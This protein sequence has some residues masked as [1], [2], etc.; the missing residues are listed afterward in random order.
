[1]HTPSLC[2][3]TALTLCAGLAPLAGAGTSDPWADFVVDFNQGS[4]A[5]PSFADPTTAL[6]SPERFTGEG[7]F[8]GAVTPFNSAFGTD[9]LVSIGAGGSLTLGFDEPIFND[10]ANPFGIDL[11]VFGNSFL[12]FGTNEVAS[13]G[14]VIEVSQTGLDGE[15]FTITGVGA[16]GAFPTLGYADLTDPFPSLPGMVETNF[17]LPMDPSLDLTGLTTEQVYAAYGNSGGGAGVDIGTVGLD[18]IQFVRISNP[19][20]SQTT[21]EIDAV[22]AVP[23]PSALMLGLLAGCGAAR[24]K[25]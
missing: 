15:W 11:L 16:D 8:P 25:R 2:A 3:L 1:M 22:V 13:D 21:P 6:G 20:D 5:S 14:G 7:V 12:I 4:G 19:I 17:Q 10:P 18:W 9:E 24:R 23:A